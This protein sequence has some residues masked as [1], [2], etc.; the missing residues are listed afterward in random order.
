MLRAL[1]PAVSEKLLS[2]LA[3]DM[4]TSTTKSRYKDIDPLLNFHL[5]VLHLLRRAKQPRLVIKYRELATGVCSDRLAA[6]QGKSTSD[7]NVDVGSWPC[8]C[9]DCKPLLVSFFRARL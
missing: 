3:S 8:D 4:K 6:A 7:H 9:E 1:S 5:P 2:I